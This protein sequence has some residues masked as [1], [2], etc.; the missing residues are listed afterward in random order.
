M[1]SHSKRPYNSKRRQA[2]A[3]E[4]RRQILAAA[5]KL[6][7]ERGYSGATIEAIAQEAEVAAETVFAVFGNKRTLLARV[8]DVAVGGDDQPIPLLQ[9]PG[10]QAVLALAD[11]AQFLQRFTADISGI[12]VRVA[13]LFDVLRAAAKV[14]PDMAELLGNLLDERLRNMETVAAHLR[15]IAQLQPGMDGTRAA[16]TIWSLTSPELFNL[17]VGERGWSREEYARWLADALVRVLLV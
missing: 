4:T 8:M 13:P 15:S 1:S 3:L 5:R 16:E 17:L 11:P 2:Q 6:F 12:L 9:R 7:L 10:P 14:E